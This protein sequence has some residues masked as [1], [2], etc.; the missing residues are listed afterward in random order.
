MIVQVTCGEVK[1]VEGLRQSRLRAVTNQRLDRCRR[2]RI[3]PK[4]SP[5]FSVFHSSLFPRFLLHPSHPT[6][7][8]RP[9]HRNTYSKSVFVPSQVAFT[10]PVF[11]GIASW[12]ACKLES[13][14]RRR[15]LPRQLSFDRKPAPA[16]EIC[17]A[18]LQLSL[19]DAP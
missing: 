5:A 18:G 7:S 13:P 15:D 8:L 3:N 9:S 10:P 1:K 2:R 12:V 4:Q 11:C 19:K 16:L 6:R 14:T 17:R